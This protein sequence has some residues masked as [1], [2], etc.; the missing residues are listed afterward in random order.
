M[1]ISQGLLALMSLVL[2]QSYKANTIVP[3][4]QLGRLRHGK[5]LKAMQTMQDD[6]K[7]GHLGWL[8]PPQ[9]PTL[10]C[11]F[12]GEELLVRRILSTS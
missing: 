5:V 12:S 1:S 4:L 9:L 11:T 2:K 8:Q 10:S 6:L 3:I 7:P